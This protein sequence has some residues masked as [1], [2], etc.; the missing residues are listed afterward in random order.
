MRVWAR[1]LVGT[2]MVHCCYCGR[3]N[4]DERTS[5]RECG[6]VLPTVYDFCP[7]A[8]GSR[9]SGFIVGLALIFA[10][11]LLAFCIASFVLRPKRFD[12]I[13]IRGTR[14]FKAQVT[15][16]LSLLKS[17]SPRAYAIVTNY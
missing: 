11:L 7:T 17:K 3:D 13:E 12:I 2:P 9:R 8:S 1:V 16:A 15:S 6:T 4:E 14:E 5:C 10:A